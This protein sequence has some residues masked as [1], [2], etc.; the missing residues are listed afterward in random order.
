[1]TSDTLWGHSLSIYKILIV[2]VF[3]SDIHIY[4]DDTSI[5]V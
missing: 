4:I 1:M 2:Q 3:L 5:S